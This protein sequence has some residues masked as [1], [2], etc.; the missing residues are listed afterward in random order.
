MIPDYDEKKSNIE[1]VAE[2]LGH[3]VLTLLG[4]FFIDR[5]VTYVPTYSGRAHGTFNIFSVLLI[6]LIFA[7]EANT[8]VGT[9]KSNFLLNV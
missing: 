9:K 5:I 6:I 2:V 4:L 7:Y 8:K 1:L 3:L